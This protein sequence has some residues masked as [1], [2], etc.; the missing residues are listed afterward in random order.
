MRLE[1]TTELR[2]KMRH[3]QDQFYALLQKVVE[4]PNGGTIFV[5][6][7]ELRVIQHD[8]RFELARIRPGRL[9]HASVDPPFWMITK[10]GEVLRHVRIYIEEEK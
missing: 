4:D 2:Q 7:D 8:S 6:V 3:V 9:D 5:S 10:N 1:L